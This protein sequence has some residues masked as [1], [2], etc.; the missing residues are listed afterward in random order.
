MRKRVDDNQKKI[1]YALREFGTVQS[2]ADIG[3]GCP[4]I[5]FGINNNNYLIEIKDGS[6]FKSQQKLT[7]DQEK[8]HYYWQGQVEVIS[9]VEEALQFVS[10]IING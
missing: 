3:K 7:N 4:D 1:V 8:W 10:D 6:K 9:S 5:L 2:L